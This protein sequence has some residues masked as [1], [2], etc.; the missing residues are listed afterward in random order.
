M[1]TTF[2]I[3]LEAI[4]DNYRKSTDIQRYKNDISRLDIDAKS[5]LRRCLSAG[6]DC[7]SLQELID[8]L[9]TLSGKL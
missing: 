3:R 2:H 4:K 6:D 5:A 7:N 8:Y 9:D 1:I